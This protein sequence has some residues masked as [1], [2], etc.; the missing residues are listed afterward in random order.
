MHRPT[1][2]L[3]LTILVTAFA[4]CSIV[5]GVFE[6]NVKAAPVVGFQPGRIID[7][8]VFTNSSTM[9]SS[10]I[11]QF[12]E[13]QVPVCDTNGTQ[14]SEF[15][16]GT[17]AQWAAA[18]GYS[19]P[20]TCLRDFSEG[21][22]SASQI[23]YDVSQEFFINPQVLIVLLQK[24]QSLITDDWPI[25]DSAQYRTATGYGCP[26]TAACASEYFGLT[27]QLT[28][29]GR[30]F[31]AIMNASPTWFT[32]YV[33]GNNYIQ[34]N[35]NSSCGGST[36][37]IQ[38]RSTQA[39]YNYTPYQP[40]QAALDA[41]WGQ[42][43]CGAYGNRNFYLYFTSWFGATNT[44]PLIRTASSPALFYTDGRYRYSIPSMSIADQYG[45]GLGDVG[46]IAQSYIDV[47][48]L[49]PASPTL[50]FFAK[51]DSDSDQD[52]SDV[53]LISKGQRF[54]ISSSEQMTRFG[55]NVAETTQLPSHAINRLPLAGNLSNFIKG[56]DDFVYQVDAGSKSGIFQLSLY[57]S[58]NSGGSVSRLS[59]FI[60]D[61]LST[62]A[63]LVQGYMTLKGSDGRVWLVSG[64][65][66]RYIGTANVLD[67]L[68]LTKRITSFTS[69]QAVIGTQGPA[70]TCIM[71]DPATS[72][73]Y[74]MD[75]TR[76]Y[77]LQ[78]GWG[79]S[80]SLAAD[81]SVFSDK[82]T[83]AAQDFSVFNNSATGQLFT[84]EAGEKRYIESM[85]VLGE[86][87]QQES[88][89]ITISSGSLSSIP[90]GHN[91]I[92]SGQLLRESST[93]R[94]YV[95]DRD[96]RIHIPTMNIFNSLG[97]SVAALRSVSS[98]TISNYTQSAQSLKRIFKIGSTTYIADDGKK[99]IIP[100][101][102]ISDYG[103]STAPTYS[104]GVA[105][106]AT[107]VSAVAT[108]YVKSSSSTQLFFLENG[109]KR[110]VNSWV[111]FTSIGGTNNNITTYSS[112]YLASLPTGQSL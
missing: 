50:N 96:T 33:V 53:Y 15:G 106:R 7:D 72:T 27:N 79:L 61:R 2:L 1:K 84:I 48:P 35:P 69:T 34:Y 73:S 81:S 68:G 52:G 109:A 90:T 8:A 94:L 10:Q 31:R 20:F 59:S 105:S 3:S 71:T 12:L 111:S 104:S 30:M 40:N 74:L 83:T 43:N 21:G 62:A 44:K 87:G 110:P 67:C 95:M 45:Y 98:S 63:P 89:I 107:T 57:Q 41:G 11:Q 103:A 77:A 112:E 5:F 66:W 65:Q 54:R 86:V 36:V 17:R 9:S 97:Y 76:K 101:E 28:W 51:T 16:G 70:A 88:Q 37:N 92:A 64:S 6:T 23:I 42:V 93:G 85:S 18:R 13:A 80:A 102:I 78:T 32:P 99:Y 49:S 58:L 60:L 108:R 38:N 56:T 47:L 22:K 29:S 82:T 24:E 91:R 25:P 55:L 4:V 100:A 26:D 39:L 46:F 19:P 14:P 75:K